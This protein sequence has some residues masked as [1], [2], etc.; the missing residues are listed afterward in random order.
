MDFAD[1]ELLR[2]RETV[3]CESS[4]C[5]ASV[6]RLTCPTGSTLLLLAMLDVVARLAGTRN[7]RVTGNTSIFLRGDPG[8]P[9]LVSLYVVHSR[10]EF[11]VFAAVG[12]TSGK[13]SRKRDGRIKAGTRPAKLNLNVALRM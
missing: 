13:D 5:S 1:G 10:F 8:E 4:R 2:T 11:P 9:A 6:L 7:L 12:E 3:V